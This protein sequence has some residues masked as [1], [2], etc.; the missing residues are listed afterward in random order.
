MVKGVEKRHVVVNTNVDGI[1]FV[2][3]VDHPSHAR[4]AVS[5]VPNAEQ[6]LLGW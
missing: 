6:L 5:I 1:D 2:E 4:D 3:D